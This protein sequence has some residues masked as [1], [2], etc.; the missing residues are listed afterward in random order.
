[1]YLINH[2]AGDST[3]RKED[4]KVL[5]ILSV[6]WIRN[7]SLN[8]Y[9]LPQPLE[10]NPSSKRQTDICKLSDPD[11]SVHLSVLFYIRTFCVCLEREK[12]NQKK[13]KSQMLMA[14]RESKFVGQRTW[15]REYKLRSITFVCI[16]LHY[17]IKETCNVWN[18]PDQNQYC[19]DCWNTAEMEFSN[20]W[21]KEYP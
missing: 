3:L 15:K 19:Y 2:W 8:P 10:S 5:M 20:E 7:S 16:M 18:R 12:E 6:S 14:Y 13:K 9:Y 4:G 1:M 11:S 17:T 21:L